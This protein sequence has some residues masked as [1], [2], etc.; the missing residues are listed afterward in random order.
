[1]AELLTGREQTRHLP[2]CSSLE[3]LHDP[4]P[5]GQ[6]T[7]DE[8]GWYHPPCD[9]QTDRE[10][11]RRDA[12]PLDDERYVANRRELAG[13]RDLLAELEQAER[14][15][16]RFKAEIVDNTAAMRTAAEEM[17]RV[18]ARLAKV[19]ALVEALRSIA[20]RNVYETVG[21]AMKIARDALAAY[22]QEQ[23]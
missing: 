3:R 20:R 9:C 23:T 15:R 1:M 4:G 18:K 8:R 11:A 21:V 2:S 22:E 16:G 17:R 7:F 13:G 6:G 12:Q 10:Q 5:E 19:P 14:E